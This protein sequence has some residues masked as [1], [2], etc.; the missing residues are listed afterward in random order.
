MVSRKAGRA[1]VVGEV[2][3]AD[4]SGI[5]DESPE[6][7]VTFRKMTYLTSEFWR[8]PDVD[9]L[10]QTAVRGDDA[11]RTVFRSD[12]HYRGFDDRSQHDR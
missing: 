1:R 8:H 6:E 7:S 12:E 9:E 5:V 3:E 2:L 10:L 11:E 4:G